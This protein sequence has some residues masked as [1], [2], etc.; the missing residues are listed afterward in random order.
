MWYTHLIKNHKMLGSILRR[1]SQEKLKI[2]A[3]GYICC[4]GVIYQAEYAEN[5]RAT[6][7]VISTVWPLV[8]PCA[9]VHAFPIFIDMLDDKLKPAKKLV[10]VP[11]AG[12]TTQFRMEEEK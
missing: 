4:Y 2:C 12:T 1:A 3:V 5:H 11:E 9:T 10:R 8:L 6:V 7:A